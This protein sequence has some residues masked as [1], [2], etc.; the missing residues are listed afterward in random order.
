M[1]RRNYRLDFSNSRANINRL[2]KKKLLKRDHSL[3]LRSAYLL[4]S[5]SYLLVV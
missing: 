2:C 3:C 4:S 5:T 1:T